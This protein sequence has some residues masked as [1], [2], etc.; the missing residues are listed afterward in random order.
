MSRPV[1]ATG[2]TTNDGTIRCGMVGS[3]GQSSEKALNQGASARVITLTGTP[4]PDATDESLPIVHRQRSLL[5][6]LTRSEQDHRTMVS[7]FGLP[8]RGQF[9]VPPTTHIRIQE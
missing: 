6:L 3:G 5:V 9:H 1:V 7:E 8:R 4:P 2:V